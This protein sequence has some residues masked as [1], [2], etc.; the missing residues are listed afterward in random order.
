MAFV[1]ELLPDHQLETTAAFQRTR[2]EALLHLQ[3]DKT[4]EA[5][6]AKLSGNISHGQPPLQSGITIDG[7]SA[8][9]NG[10]GGQFASQNGNI[11]DGHPSSQHVG[12]FY[13]GIQLGKRLDG[14]T[15]DSRRWKILADFWTEMILYIAPS[16]N[17]RDHIQYLA[18]GGEFIT[19]LWA[20]L[21]HA[22]IL[23]RGP[24]NVANDIENRGDGSS[25][26]GTSTTQAAPATTYYS[27]NQLPIAGNGHAVQVN[28]RNA[29]DIMLG[30]T[31]H[32]LETFHTVLL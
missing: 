11:N 31:S 29:G 32:V 4:L 21:T 20:M 17:A 6:Y 1:P 30:L 24:R 19:H 14:I 23:D 5:K 18:N 3:E 16:D 27:T 10:S 9:Q 26:S 22:G 7:Q 25:Q 15:D 12:I 8:T 13:K 28:E 2:K